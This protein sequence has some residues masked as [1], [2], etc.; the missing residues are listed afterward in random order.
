V[1]ALQWTW[2]VAYPDQGIENQVEL[3]LPVDRKVTFNITSRDVV[4]S[5]WVPAFLM[6]IDAVPGHTTTLSLLATEEGDYTDRPLYRIQCAELCGVSHS[7]MR[8]PVRVVS[9]EEFD[10][11]VAEK[12]ATA[13]KE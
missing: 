2:L 4:H 12:S 9:Q 8:I 3:V 6:K 1:Q 13:V 10:A 11:W 5:F 7:S